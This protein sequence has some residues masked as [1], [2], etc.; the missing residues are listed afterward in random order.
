MANVSLDE[1][2]R[3]TGTVNLVFK[4]IEAMTH[5]QQGGKTD[6]EGRKKMMED[7][8]RKILPGDTEVVLLGTPDWDAS[9]APLI[10]SFRISG[11]FAVAAGK[12]LMVMQHLFQV[13]EK[14]QFPSAARSNA[15]CFQAPWQEA[16]EVH[17]TIPAGMEVESL[18]P[19]DTVK[20]GY[21]VYKVQQKQEAPNKIF[22]RRDF[23]MG[24]GLF[25]PDQYKEVKG[26]FDKVKADD[27]QPAL[28]RVT[29]IAAITN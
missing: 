4:G 28:V 13:S 18:A 10:V 20:L 29:P 21:A 16:D 19:D 24:Q 11:P 9:E 17:I 6:A 14:P 26:F 27:N 22:S 1:H 12:R 3:L 7:E 5:R 2:G 15:I 25:T 23:V 8:L